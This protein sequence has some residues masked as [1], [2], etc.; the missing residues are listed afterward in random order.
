MANAPTVL[1]Q[2]LEQPRQSDETT[3][4]RSAALDA[5]SSTTSSSTSDSTLASCRACKAD[6][7]QFYNGWQQITGSYYLPTRAASRAFGLQGKGKAKLAAPNSALEA[8]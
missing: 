8:W 6:F 1:D 2:K 7:A 5:D 4:S 3:Q